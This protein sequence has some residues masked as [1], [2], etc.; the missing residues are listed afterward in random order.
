MPA[1][2]IGPERSIGIGFAGE[3]RSAAED[4]GASSIAKSGRLLAAAQPEAAVRA[5]FL[6]EASPGA[7]P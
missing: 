2:A 3:I 6:A 5:A 7:R 4:A 1:L